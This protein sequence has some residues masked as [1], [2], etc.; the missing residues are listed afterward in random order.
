MKERTKES[1]GIKELISSNEIQQRI[2]ALGKEISRDFAGEEVFLICILKGAFLFF[3]GLIRSVTIPL[4]IDFMGC[5]SYGDEKISSG[6]HRLY[7]DLKEDISGKNV[8]IVEDIV[9]TGL[10]INEIFKVLRTKEPKKLKLASLLSKPSCRKIDISIDYL[11]FEI[12]DKFVVG[13]GLDYKQKLRGLP[14][15]GVLDSD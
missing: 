3:S 4:E 14:Y 9:D 11:G 10:T 2:C 1:L 8:V 6:K 5:S 15:I 12:E 7:L 13:Y